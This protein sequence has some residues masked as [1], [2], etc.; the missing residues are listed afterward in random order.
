MATINGT[1]GNDT[2]TGTA[3]PDTINGLAGDDLLSGLDGDD[4]LNGGA[5][6]N[7]LEGG[8]GFNTATYLDAT[9]AVT[10][11]LATTAYQDTGYSNDQLVSIQKLVGSLFGDHLAGG[12]GNDTL[13]VGGDIVTS[14]NQSYT[15]ANVGDILDGGDGNDTLLANGNSNGDVLNGGAGDD[16]ITVG[17]SGTGIGYYPALVAIDGDAVMINGGDGAD[18]LRAVSHAIIDGGAGDDVITIGTGPR[19]AVETRP[20]TYYAPPGTDTTVRLTGGAGHDTFAIFNPMATAIITDFVIGEDKL[21]V[22]GSRNASGDNQTTIY[23]GQQGAD[24]IFFSSDNWNFILARLPNTD[25]SLL[26]AADFVG[27]A[28]PATYLYGTSGADELHGTGAALVYGAEG[29]DILF[30]G[31]A[32]STLRGG[33]GA[34]TLVSGAGDDT[35]YGY[36]AAGADAATITDTVD[37]RDA[38]AAVAV[39]LNAGSATG[40]GGNDTLIGIRNVTGS[41]FN[42]TMTAR[43]DGSKLDGAAGDDV[44][45]G[46]GEA[47]VLWGGLGADTLTGGGGADTFAFGPGQS[48]S[49]AV[50]TITD[51][52]TKLDRIDLTALAPTA[53]SLVRVGADTLVFANSVSG[54]QTVIG[55]NGVINGGDIFVAGQGVAVT[56]VGDTGA[57]TLIGGAVNDTLDGGAGDDVL[58]GGL[59]GDALTGGA[60]A[61]NFKYES[62]AQSVSGGSDLITDFQT[63]VDKIDFTAIAPDTV[64]ILRSGGSSFIYATDGLGHQLELASL[65]D[66]NAADV[67]TGGSAA[68]VN[69]TGGAGDDLL[70]GA[71][72]RDNFLGY[73][74]A[75]ILLGGSGADNLTG[76]AGADIF[77]YTQALDSTGAAQDVITDFV[78]GVDKIEL[79]LSVTEVSLVRLGSATFIFAN[80][81][82]GAMQ[83]GVNS[84]VNISDLV[85]QTPRGV[86]LIGDGDSE[87]LTGGALNDVI[88]AGDGVDLVTGGGGGDALWG[89]AGA[90]TFKYLLAS[91]SNTAGSD[92]IFD[93]QTGSDKI[94]LTGLAPTEVSI[95]RSGGSSFLFINGPGGASQL[96]ATGD[97]NAN[98]LVLGSNLST[99]VIGDDTANVL[100]SGAQ[101]DILQAGGGADTLTGGGLSDLMWGGAGADVFKYLA[102]TDSNAAGADSIFDFQSGIDKLDLS[103]VRTG[104]SDTIG[105]LSSGGSTFVFVDLHGDGVGDMVIQLTNTASITSNDYIF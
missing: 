9:T 102:A 18:T 95:V 67:V 63:G 33:A 15:Y 10:V 84:D 64:T 37:Y 2:L 61:D 70:I 68:G 30:A 17:F 94:D 3:D 88:Q 57:D 100:V 60:G 25:A 42:D 32:G 74:G 44:L 82:N 103:A 81:P 76:G 5:G 12:A 92:T 47:D 29:D 71:A 34:D 104:A 22:R 58:I 89:G 99:Y 91:D 69:L 38:T 16:T 87:T 13:D 90:D 105:V 49:E 7:R 11:S 66:V 53:V 65:T 101:T 50:D 86:Y 19:N 79:N 40:G 93:F 73:D 26:S 23:A 8:A 36:G 51:F 56:M 39:A 31:A 6:K 96:A 62:L 75:D 45:V 80:T 55:V 27:Y 98:D 28:P 52:Q 24:T 14:G 72:G 78:S 41:A 43:F 20:A 54:P 46:L 59:G 48:T 77:R 97:V 85:L 1:A 83:I 35:L 4:V 21:D